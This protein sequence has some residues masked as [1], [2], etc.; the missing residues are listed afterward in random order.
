MPKRYDKAYFDR[1][2]RGRNRVSTPA[3]VRRKVVLAVSI[4]EYFLRRPIRNVLDVGCGEGAWLPH[5]RALRPRVSYLGLD[6]SDY[7]VARFGKKRNIRKAAF[8]ELPSLHLDDSYD[9]IVC[10]DALHYVPDTEVAPGI[11]E[12]VR[13]LDGVAYLEVLTKEDEIVGDLDALM[14]RPAAWYRKTFTAAGLIPVGPFTWSAP[15]LAPTFAELES[16]AR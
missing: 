13:L 16:P 6:P 15:E 4:A 2:Y 14:Q 8:G 9:L 11:R 1:W 10:A 3:E 12:L 7:V 5:L